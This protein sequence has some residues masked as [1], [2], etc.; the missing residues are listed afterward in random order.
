MRRDALFFMV[1]TELTFQLDRSE[2]KDEAESNT[3]RQGARQTKT[4]LASKGREAAAPPSMLVTLLTS[5]RERSLLKS[6]HW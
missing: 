5:H 4:A 2:L 1:V 6:A 3:A